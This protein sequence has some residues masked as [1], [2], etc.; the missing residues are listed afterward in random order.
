MGAPG[1]AAPIRDERIAR[2]LRQA[3]A[4]MLA[5]QRVPARHDDAV[6][7]SVARQV[8]EPG[9][10]R[11]GLGRHADIGLAFQQHFRHL[12]GRALMQMQHH[13]G[14][15]LPEFLDDGRQ[16]VARLRMRGRDRQHALAAV[17]VFRARMP[18]VVGA[19]QDLL[20][21]R[22]DQLTGRPRVSGG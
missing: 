9:I 18:D 11:H 6:A 17:G 10:V 4:V 20:H 8:H 5:L 7:P 12:L 14:I 16:R 15:T 19:L 2:Q 22:Q 21:Q 13:V 3:D 1:I